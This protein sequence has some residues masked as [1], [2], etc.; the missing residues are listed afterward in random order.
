[1]IDAFNQDIDAAISDRSGA[2]TAKRRAWMDYDR[3]LEGSPD[4]DVV[5]LIDQLL[6]RSYKNR[7]NLNGVSRHKSALELLD[8]IRWQMQDTVDSSERYVRRI[9]E[10]E[11]SSYETT[12]DLI[13]LKAAKRRIPSNHAV[14][15]EHGTEI[16]GDRDGEARED[17]LQGRLPV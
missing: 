12:N 14:D 3:K 15:A 10:E 6:L 1:M 13:A 11:P 5:V 2:K 17:V 16:T 7:R 9:A 8:T 4:K